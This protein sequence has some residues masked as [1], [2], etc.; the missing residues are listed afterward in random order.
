M[1]SEEK[2][3][4]DFYRMYYTVLRVGK[5]E[6]WR[7][8]RKPR[9]LV[10]MVVLFVLWMLWWLVL[11][12]FFNGIMFFAEQRELPVR[13]PSR[14]V[15]S[16]S[17]FSQ[18]VF[19]MR[20]CLDAVFA[21]SQTPDRVIITI[22]RK[23]RALEKTTTFPA[24]LYLR[25]IPAA[26]WSD[27]YVDTNRYNESEVNMVNWFSNYVGTAYN[28]HVNL[29]VHKTSSVYEMGIL[30]VQFID[31][32]WGPATKLI[33]ALL[34]EKDPSTVII[35]F[36]DDMVYNR[37]TVKWLSTHMQPDIALSFGCQ[38]WNS[39]MSGF[40]AFTLWDPPYMTT[41]RVCEGWL[42]GWAA[43]A[44]HV[45]SFGDDI[46]TFI[47]SLPAGCFNNDDMWL[48]GYIARHGVTRI[49]APMVLRHVNH[50]RNVDFSLS[51]IV[52]FRDK[53]YSCGRY[54]FPR[55]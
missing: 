21:Q 36:D 16:I 35:T 40:V 6:K 2:S 30:T 50:S 24:D 25:L 10:L 39:D 13:S 33:G 19:H 45:S 48:S 47:Q 26:W 20:A 23:F 42:T 12:Q 37:D 28:Y 53:G 44:Y 54:L 34:L 17:S 11:P 14:T 15:V 1:K 27:L 55:L 41:P 8:M 7:M 9:A 31:D 5:S 4:P 22:P 29:D 51:T 38:M 46:Y 43:I 3:A 52:N 32:D 18:R 49:Y